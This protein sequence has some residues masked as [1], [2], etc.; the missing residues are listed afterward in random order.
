MQT[1][2]ST[3]QPVTYQV[4]FGPNGTVEVDGTPTGGH[5]TNR[6]QIEEHV[7]EG[8]FQAKLPT[9][10][11][12]LVDVALAVY[13]ADRLCRRRTREIDRYRYGWSRHLRLQIPVVDPVLWGDSQL[14]NCLVDVLG[15]LTED[16]WEFEFLPRATNGVDHSY[17]RSLFP[18][19]LAPPVRAALFS[20]GLDSL[21]GLGCELADH[22]VGSFVLFAGRTNFRIEKIQLD[23]AAELGQRLGRQILPC[24]VPYGFRGRPAKAGNQDENTQRSRGFIFG[25][26]GAVTALMAGTNRLA[27]YENGIGAINLPY[28]R[29]QL[30]THMTRAAHPLA[31]ARLSEFITLATGQ[32]F[33]FEL[34]FLGMTKGEMCARLSEL[35]VQDLVAETVSCDGFPQRVQSRPQCGLCTSCLLRRQSLHAAGLAHLDNSD[36]YRNDIYESLDGIDARRLYPFRAMLHQVAE[37]QRA[38]R[39][40]DPWRALVSSY[41]ELLEIALVNEWS[42]LSVPIEE[43]LVRLYRTYCEEWERFPVRPPT[44]P[45][46]ALE[47][48]GDSDVE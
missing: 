16:R 31:M 27:I 42:L 47:D 44:V 48:G 26:L 10:L 29:A 38:L 35:G 33:A 8:A 12:D 39:A 22:A 18:V 2:V 41:P 45:W 46:F 34:P 1:S 14:H 24:V 20:G 23:L 30:G 4:I 28:T 5:I 6:F 3:P 37:L 43:Q 19:D 21:A 25:I 36:R 9:A 15:F 7:I 40:P 11:S 13:I 32:S 17:Q